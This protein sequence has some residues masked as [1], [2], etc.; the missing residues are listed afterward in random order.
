MSGHANADE[1]PAED[2][3]VASNDRA[4][5]RAA[6]RRRAAKLRERREQAGQVRIQ[7]WVPRERV[8]Y[9][10][11]VLQAAVAGANALPPDPAQQAALD[12][13]RAEA[14]T[15]Q[16]EL[17][18]VRAASSQ[19]A[20]QARL[21]EA[22]AL[23]RAEAAERSREKAARELATMQAEIEAAQAREQAAQDTAAA[24][25]GELDGI[26]GRRGWRGVLLRLAGA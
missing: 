24:L 2:Q 17:Q 8:A 5:Q 22:E 11:Q 21:A 18:E 25:Q 26:K 1:I 7:T 6:D 3:V 13:A 16:A 12:V 9:T 23:A 15:A 20:E 14:A 4:E 19:Q 10:R